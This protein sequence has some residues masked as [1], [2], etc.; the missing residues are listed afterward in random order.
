MN[1]EQHQGESPL[2][3]GICLTGLAANPQ[4]T[5]L[6]EHALAKMLKVSDR[7]VQRMVL[8]GQLPA[9]I[10]LGSRRMWMVGKLIEFLGAE[11]DRLKK[12]AHRIA[13]LHAGSGI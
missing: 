5:L 4:Y 12:E 3:D 10:K 6:D 9:G 13:A 2:T 8:R 7:T 11:S 1:D